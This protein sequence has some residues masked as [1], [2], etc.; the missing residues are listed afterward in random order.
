[1]RNKK[2]LTI[3]SG[4]AVLG[5]SI[6]LGMSSASQSALTIGGKKN[7]IVSFKD[8]SSYNESAFEEKLTD[9]VGSGNYKINAKYSG[10]LFNGVAVTLNSGYTNIIKSWSFVDGMYNDTV[11]SLPTST[12]DQGEGINAVADSGNVDSDRTTTSYSRATMKIQDSLTGINAPS[13][14][15]LGTVI[16]ILDTGLYYNQI[17]GKATDTSTKAFRPIAVDD[18]SDQLGVK[19]STVKDLSTQLGTDGQHKGG[20]PKVQNNKIIWGYDYADDDNVVSPSYSNNHGTH[21]ASLAAAN[22]AT[23]EGA[24]PDAQVAVFKVFSDSSSGATT[25]SI[26]KAMQD[27]DK[28]DFID[29]INLSLGS[30]L[31]QMGNDADDFDVYTIVQ[32]LEEKG[33]QVNFAGGNDGR[34]SYNKTTGFFADSLTTDTVEPSEYGSYALLDNANIVSS[35]YL[36]KTYHKKL[37]LNGDEANRAADFTD[38]NT[39]YPIANLFDS[40]VSLRYIYIGGTGTAEWYDSNPNV[41]NGMIKD[42]SSI[43]TIAV[44]NRG[45]AYFS[46]LADTAQKYGAKGIIIINNSEAQDNSLGRFDLSSATTPITIPVVAAYYR[47]IQ[48]FGEAGSTTGEISYDATGKLED[49]DA[50]KQMSLFSSDGPATN[51]SFNPDI[52]APGTDI[53]GAVNG[54]YETM[55]GTSMATPNF[56]GAMATILSNHVGDSEYNKHLMARIQSTAT[57]LK[58]DSKYQIDFDHDKNGKWSA[59]SK[60]QFGD[61]DI[62]NYASPRRAGAGMINVNRVL[63]DKVWL[64]TPVTDNSGKPVQADGKYEGT[65]KAKLQMGYTDTDGFSKGIFKAPIIIHNE[66]TSDKH[67]QVSLYVA[68]PEVRVGA[69]SSEL[70]TLGVTSSML[71]KGLTTTDLMSTDDHMVA[72]VVLTE[73]VTVKPGDNIYD[74]NVDINAKTNNALENY[75]KKYFNYGTFLEGYVLLQPTDQKPSSNDTKEVRANKEQTWLRMPYLGF[76]GDYSTA[77]AVENF[78]FERTSDNTLNSDI[79]QQVARNI[80]GGSQNA[81]FSSQVYGASLAQYKSANEYDG[82]L[83]ALD[84]VYKGDKTLADVNFAKLGT[85]PK[86]EAYDTSDR[87]K[88]VAGVKNFSDLLIIKQFVN[89]SLYSGKVTLTDASGKA[90]QSVYLQDHAYTTAD[91]QTGKLENSLR[92]SDGKSYQLLKSFLTS[93]LI[94][95]R[96]Y[97]PLASAAIPLKDASGK[98]LASGDYKLVFDYVLMAKK[99]GTNPSQ[100]D[101]NNTADGRFTQQKTYTIHIPAESEISKPAVYSYGQVGTDFVI[102]VPND[103]KYV[104]FGKTDTD[105]SSVQTTV[106]PQGQTVHYVVV[107]SG[108][109]NNGVLRGTSVGFDGNATSFI[110]DGKGKGQS[111]IYGS[112]SILDQVE[113]F[114]FSAT[115]D[116]ANRTLTY[117]ANVLGTNGAII[118]NYFNSKNNGYTFNVNDDPANKEFKFTGVKG[119]SRG[120]KVIDISSAYYEYD[121]ASG[122]F[123][124]LNLPANVVSIQFT[125]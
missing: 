42:Y 97:A 89:R 49:N 54:K 72:N 61:L 83:S 11:Y 91:S 120:N 7:Y 106:T 45:G 122:Q 5:G 101:E 113:A 35:S 108:R 24:A 13:K 98:D 38:Q 46:E 100:D 50:A 12:V 14:Q 29:T 76:Y 28:M 78:D 90:L 32:K 47:D 19:L 109:L 41:E 40:G 116:E 64:E 88:F 121:A 107:P 22:G 17:A 80:V 44:V 86:N 96:Y 36:D 57:P 99:D 110:I 20:A 63:N 43:P 111:A 114:Y 67:Y 103:T 81:D 124:I 33:V 117:T 125:F 15:G 75:V 87:T 59:S 60:E 104:K 2:I 79:Q 1:M 65:G 68:V 71:A 9:L 6:I 102:Y 73:D 84:E 123:T 30:A 51:L 112:E 18:E 92:N 94:S 62:D 55:S 93:S 21:V 74:I 105:N 95:A 26:L 82:A 39:D 69:D 23:Y 115:F 4:I 8:S 31:F 48:K 37:I 70:S 66:D 119:I 56:T 10:N 27:I 118:S 16:G 3:I 52:T 85:N 25:S 34:A 58:D 53:L 77:P